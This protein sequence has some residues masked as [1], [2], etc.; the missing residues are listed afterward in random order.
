MTAPDDDAPAPEPLDDDGLPV[1]DP[2][3]I[4]DEELLALAVDAVILADPVARV[5]SGEIAQYQA[6][7][8]AIVDDET[9]RLYLEV[10]SRQNERFADLALATARWAF[11]EGR[12]HPL[13]PTPKEGGAS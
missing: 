3:V 2:A 12:R 11:S 9:W 7:L 13:P 8:R 4:E 1:L 6:W 5:R 10:E